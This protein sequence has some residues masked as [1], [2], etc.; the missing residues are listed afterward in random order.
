MGGAPISMGYIAFV[1]IGSL[2]VGTATALVLNVER[3]SDLLMMLQGA[4]LFIVGT[5][6][7]VI[8]L[9]AIPFLFLDH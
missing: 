5:L 6:L 8:I 7:G 3:K 4:V 9:G 1:L 2:V